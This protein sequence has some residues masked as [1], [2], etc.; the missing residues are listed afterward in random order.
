[1]KLITSLRRQQQKWSNPN[2]SK[3]FLNVR[4]GP[5]MAEPFFYQKGQLL[6]HLESGQL[7]SVRP[8]MLAWLHEH[9]RHKMCGLISC[10]EQIF[11][12][13]NE[14]AGA[15][16]GSLRQA[17]SLL[18][19]IIL[20]CVAKLG[21]KWLRSLTKANVCCHEA[22][23]SFTK[24]MNKN[25]N[26]VHFAIVLAQIFSV[27]QTWNFIVKLGARYPWINDNVITSLQ[28]LENVANEFASLKSWVPLRHNGEI[29]L[30][31][32]FQRP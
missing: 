12:R 21:T 28:S 23:W 4:P 27:I 31:V 32:I 17:K 9:L 14:D 15:A 3:S 16:N 20:C 26:Q 24:K 29:K 13:L 18:S 22:S 8:Q 25:D 30:V 19:H 5:K 2:R 7:H 11:Q 10:Q 6:L 1:M